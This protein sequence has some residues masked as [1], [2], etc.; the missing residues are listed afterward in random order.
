MPETSLWEGSWTLHPLFDAAPYYFFA[1]VT[2]IEFS[3]VIFF[4]AV[5]R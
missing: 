1:A 5:V 2:I 4:A 3:D